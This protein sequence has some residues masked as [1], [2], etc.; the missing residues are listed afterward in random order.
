MP[1]ASLRLIGV[2]HAS[3]ESAWRTPDIKA[4]QGWLGSVAATAEQQGDVPT[5]IT[6][7]QSQLLWERCLRKELGEGATGLPS[8]VRLSRDTWQRLADA[9]V[10]IREVARSAK[11]QDQR[12]FASAAG[13]YAAVLENERWVD[14]AGLAALALELIVAERVTPKKRYVLIA[15]VPL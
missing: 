12:L 1:P 5:R 2:C 6:A 10:S 3:G 4:W 9:R 15:F 7:H 13:R 11:N 8:L 14:D